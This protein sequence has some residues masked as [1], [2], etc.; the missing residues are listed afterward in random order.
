MTNY[1]FSSMCTNC[2][3]M[4]LDILLNTETYQN[5]TLKYSKNDK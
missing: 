5:I 3:L 2:I 4:S 1:K